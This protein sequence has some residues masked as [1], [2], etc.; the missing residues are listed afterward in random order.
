[1]QGSAADLIKLAMLEVDRRL[2]AGG[3]Q[4]GIVLQIHDELLL[5]CPA[6]ETTAVE[7]LLP[8]AMRQAMHLDVPLEV[9]VLSGKTWAET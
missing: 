8:E 2:A 9:S 4:A 7:Q 1:M 3:L 5:D 6:E